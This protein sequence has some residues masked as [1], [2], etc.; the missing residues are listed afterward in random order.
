MPSSFR[1]DLSALLTA[2]AL[3]CTGCTLEVGED[4]GSGIEASVS[5]M[6]AASADGWN[7]GDLDAF[8]AMYAES[9]TTSLVTPDGLV[10][11]LDQIREWYGPAFQ[12]GARRD[13]MRVEELDIRQL[14]PLIGV[15][16]GRRVFR[17]GDID[18][19]S[20]WVTMI[21]RRVGDGWRVLH[22]HPSAEAGE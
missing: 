13:S 11:G 18:A 8:L 14:P 20:D 22:E 2:T 4:E 6:L 19:R 12:P 15:V 3:I 10:E 21:V 16:T 17:V 9:S 5:A 7:D 1:T